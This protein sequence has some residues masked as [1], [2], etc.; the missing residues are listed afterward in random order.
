MVTQEVDMAVLGLEDEAHA[1]FD[2]AGELDDPTAAE[3]VDRYPRGC[4]SACG[5]R[6]E[7]GWRQCQNDLCWVGAPGENL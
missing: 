2:P 3:E 5:E 7:P 1:E 4:C 6:F